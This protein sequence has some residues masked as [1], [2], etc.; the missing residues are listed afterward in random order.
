MSENKLK[1]VGDKPL[2]NEELRSWLENYI[3]GQPHHTTEVLARSQ[4]IGVPRVIIEEYL[5]GIYFLPKKSGGKGNSRKKSYIEEAIWRFRISIEGTA[6]HNYINNF[7]K[8][9]HGYKFKLHVRL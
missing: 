7:W 9:A 3:K 2:W 5:E 1:I 8:H 4:Y 6:R